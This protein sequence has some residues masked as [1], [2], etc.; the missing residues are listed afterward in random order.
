M[1]TFRSVASKVSGVRRR[2]LW[3]LLMVGAIVN[4]I[5]GAFAIKTVWATPPQGFTSTNLVGP[6]TLDE[7]DTWAHADDWRIRLKSR[8]V[9]D[10]YVT[11]LQIVPGGHGGWHSHPGPSII[12]VKA[13]TATFY[14]E[15]NDFMPANYATGTAFV[16]DAGCV[17]LLANEGNVDLEVIVVQIVPRGAPRR[18]DEDS[19]F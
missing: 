16:E 15:C 6:A 14:D 2:T 11:H 12:S 3:Q 19:P 18:I 9:S 13:G 8:D 17:H 7:F 10:V 1:V 5:L 4:C